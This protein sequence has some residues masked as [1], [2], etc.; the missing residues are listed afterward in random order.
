ACRHCGILSSPTNRN[1]MTLEL[2]ER[3][4]RQAAALSP[5]ITTLV[6]TGGEP[7]L[8]VPDLERMIGLCYDLGL[9]TRVVTNGFWA[10]DTAR[11]RDILHR[12]RLAGIDTKI[13][14][15]HV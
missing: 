10:R 3:C 13:G 9:S 7:F 8:F 5:K 11:G 15:A 6:F 12:L 1:R 2:A 14:R 4:I